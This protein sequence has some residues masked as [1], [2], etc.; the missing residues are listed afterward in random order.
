M[1]EMSN[2]ESLI[3]AVLDCIVRY[4]FMSD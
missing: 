4:K 1:A 3:Q 2:M